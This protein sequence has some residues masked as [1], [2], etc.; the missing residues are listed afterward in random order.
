M[1]SDQSAS[2]PPNNCQPLSNTSMGNVR[3][4]WTNQRVLPSHLSKV[5][6][7]SLYVN[8]LQCACHLQTML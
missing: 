6:I 2:M 1:F 4:V 5:L 3:L 8:L 7:R